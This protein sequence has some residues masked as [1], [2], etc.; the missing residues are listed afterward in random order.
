[1]TKMPPIV[2]AVILTKQATFTPASTALILQLA[3]FVHAILFRVW[4]SERVCG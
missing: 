4:N 3:V 2:I 1:M